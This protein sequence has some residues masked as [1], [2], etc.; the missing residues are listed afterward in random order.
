M[1]AAAE[2]ELPGFDPVAFITVRSRR[3]D[4]V[5][6]AQ[7]CR[8]DPERL[9]ATGR[10]RR[11]TGAAY[12]EDRWGPLETFTWPWREVPQVRWTSPEAAE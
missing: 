5:F 8:Q 4:G 10:W 7:A 2:N 12:T 3:A 1:T 6:V 9:T 11:R